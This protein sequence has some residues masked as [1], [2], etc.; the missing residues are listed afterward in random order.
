MYIIYAVITVCYEF[1][2][3]LIPATVVDDYNHKQW[4][5]SVIYG[6]YNDMTKIAPATFVAGG[7][8]DVQRKNGERPP[9]NRN[10]LSIMNLI[11]PDQLILKRNLFIDSADQN[12]V[13]NR[14]HVNNLAIY[15]LGN[16]IYP[17]I[18]CPPTTPWNFENILNKQFP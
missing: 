17:L 3:Q 12:N 4:I 1:N 15:F 13:A 10:G 16:R 5:I 9:D 11:V 2:L 8:T 7:G 14:F 18:L 6:S